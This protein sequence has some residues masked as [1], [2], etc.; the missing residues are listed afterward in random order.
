MSR[1]HALCLTAAALL[2]V[3]PAAAAP[4]DMLQRSGTHLVLDGKQTHLIGTNRYQLAG[5]PLAHQCV[6]KSDLNA[7]DDWAKK[8]IAQ[9][10]DLDTNVIRLWAF[11]NFAGKSGKDFSH[12]DRIV[13][14]AKAKHIRLIFVLENTWAD[15]TAG[16]IKDAGWF[17]S[18]YKNNYGYPL[19]FTSYVD[20]I[21]SHYKNEPAIAMWQ[22]LN[23]GKY[24]QDPHLL[25]GFLSTMAR[26]IKQI[27]SNHLVSG[28]AAIQCWQHQQ[29]AAD[30]KYF[31]DD[32]HIDVLDAH[33]YDSEAADWPGCMNDALQASLALGKPL[34]IGESGIATPKYSA[35]Q[36]ANYFAAKMKAAGSRKVAGYL[37][38]S[39]N[40]L[41]TYTDVFDFANTEPMAKLFTQ[42]RHDWFN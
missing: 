41:P 34:I 35:A 39:L 22:I 27:D 24:F 23:E 7:W 31:S 6:Y 3:Q 32:S 25:K 8:I 17:T 16:G 11:Q 5:G 12:F 1:L 9:A 42:A 15:C 13:R 40:T 21:V 2:F 10:A 4:R 14:Y 19:S 36:R 20:A 29:G 26:Q 37:V 18:G 33:D 38:W 28:G 30:F